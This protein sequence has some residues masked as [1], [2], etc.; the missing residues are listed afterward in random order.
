MFVLIFSLKCR[1]EKQCTKEEIPVPLEPKTKSHHF[2]KGSFSHKLGKFSAKCKCYGTHRIF[3]LTGWQHRIGS[4][5]SVSYYSKKNCHWGIF[6]HLAIR[7]FWFFSCYERYCCLFT[8]DIR[9]NNFIFS[10]PPPNMHPNICILSDV[11]DMTVMVVYKTD[12]RSDNVFQCFDIITAYYHTGMMDNHWQIFEQLQHVL[13]TIL[14]CEYTLIIVETISC[15]WQWHYSE[16][17]W[18]KIFIS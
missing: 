8:D 11:I 17:S 4:G 7:D 6:Q 14:H 16:H 18:N 9:W 12:S 15:Q 10:P 2:V 1:S 3:G 5:T 13:L